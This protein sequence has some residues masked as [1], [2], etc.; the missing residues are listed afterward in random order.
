MDS[1]F[2]KDIEVW[3]RIGVPEAERAKA[4][5]VLVSIELCGS[6]HKVG[7]TD[8]VSCGTDYAAVTDAVIKLGTMERKTIERFAEDIAAIILKNFTPESIK[9]TVCKKPDLPLDAACVTL[10]RP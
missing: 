7:T 9:V 3:T 6:L 1:I 10:I 8:D 4:Q 2:L 5:R